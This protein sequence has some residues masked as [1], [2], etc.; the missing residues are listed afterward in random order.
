MPP[1]VAGTILA[2]SA[3]AFTACVPSE[4]AAIATYFE[5]AQSV[6]ER[7]VEAG[8][9]F[10]T[11]MNVQD[12]PLDWSEAEKTELA[13]IAGT[14]TELR[15]D[16]RSMSVPPALADV[17][18]LLPQ[19][20]GEMIAAVDIIRDIAEDP[21]TATEEKADEMTAKAEE[22]ERLANEYVTRLEQVLTE[23]YPELME[24]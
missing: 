21:S 8:A 2:L 12:D 18:P 9:K 6:A 15:D 16:A 14:L 24:E 5:E 20:M 13:T 17:H 22:G 10:E 11:L 4:E 19:A 1:S 3:V 7:L 23:R